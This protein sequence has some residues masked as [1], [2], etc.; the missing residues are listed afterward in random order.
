LRQVMAPY[1]LYPVNVRKNV[2]PARLATL[3]LHSQLE[4]ILYQPD[5]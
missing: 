4:N 5:M 1:S 3:S 2:Q